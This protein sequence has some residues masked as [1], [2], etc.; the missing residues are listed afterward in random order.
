M[1]RPYDK[2]IT[3]TTALIALFLLSSAIPVPAQDQSQFT[4]AKVKDIS[5]RKYEPAVIELLDGAKS[6]IVISMYTIQA[7]EKGPIGLLIKDLEEALDRGVSVEIYLNTRFKDDQSLSVGRE[8]AYDAFRR[9]GGKIFPVTHSTRMHDKLIIVDNRYV[10]IGSANWSISSLKNNYESVTL[11]DSP[12][13]AEDMLVRLRR[14]T[15][16]GAETKKPEKVRTITKRSAILKDDSI[17]FLNSELLNDKRLFPHML[18]N[19]DVRAMDIYLLLKAYAVEQESSEYFLPI[20]QLAL[21]LNMPSEWSDSD[22][23]RQVIKSLTKLRDEYK[24]IDVN[25]GHGEDA[26]VTLKD[27]P[28][29][30]FQVKGKFLNPEYLSKLSQ[31]AKFSLLVKA[32]L[33]KEGKT[34]GSFTQRDLASRFGVN[35]NTLGDGFKEIE[36]IKE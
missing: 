4:E 30:T 7:E 26:W 9:K 20:E 32:L 36:L 21:D 24:L 1:R 17:V 15:L 33:E 31:P 35:R 19:R 18:T 28:G 5:D 2:K 16:E 27:I 34:I 11:V 25:F 6:S 10:V 22:L 13:F 29:E 3:I 8:P 12:Q 23:R 14:H